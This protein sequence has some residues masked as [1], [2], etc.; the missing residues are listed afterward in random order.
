VYEN[1]KLEA[2]LFKR[3]FVPFF[4]NIKI[5]KQIENIGSIHVELSK[6]ILEKIDVI[7]SYF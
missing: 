6:E 5:K 1:K 2:I 4:M 7:K 3:T